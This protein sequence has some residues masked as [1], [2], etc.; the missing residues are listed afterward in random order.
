MECN[1]LRVTNEMHFVPV[2]P[3][4]KGG[5]AEVGERA[6]RFSAVQLMLL[7][8]GETK[9]VEKLSCQ[10]AVV[11]LGLL[12]VGWCGFTFRVTLEFSSWLWDRK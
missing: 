4:S 8:P 9:L 2:L 3:P 10:R 6:F 12:C 5:G 11:L 1:A 7:M